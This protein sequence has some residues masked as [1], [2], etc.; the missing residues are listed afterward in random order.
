MKTEIVAL[1]GALLIGWGC[2]RPIP[3]EGGPKDTTPPKI[4][5]AKSTPNGALYFQDRAIYLTFDEW[6]TLQNVN[7]ELLVSP[8]LA[9]RPEVY[10]K[11]RTVILRFHEDEVLRPNTTYVIY[12]GTAVRDLHE[13]NP[14]Q[15]LR[16][17]FSTGDHLDS[18]SVLGVVVDAFSNE[19]VENAAV[20]LYD[21]FT[22]SA[23]VAER[24]YYLIRTDKSGQF[25]LPNVRPGIYR[26]IAVEDAD[27]NLRWK[28]EAERIAFLD[29]FVVVGPT[30]TLVSVPV[31]RM[32]APAPKG[33]LVMRRANQYGVVYLGF[34]I[35]PDSPNVRT[36]P[37]SIR[38]TTSREQDTLIVWYDNPDSLAWKLMVQGDTVPVR[39]LSKATF[40]KQH[41]LF[42]GDERIGP[43]AAGRRPVQ[44]TTPAALPPPRTITVRSGR[45][46]LIPF[47]SPIETVDT[48]RV[49][50]LADSLERRDFSLTKDS[51]Q[52]LTLRLSLSWERG[53]RY[54]L[55][56]LPG[57]LTDFWG[58]VNTDTLV[59]IFSVPTEK[60]VGTLMLSLENLTPNTSY[61]VRLLNGNNLEEERFFIA[62]G[63]AQREI[64]VDLAPVSYSVQLIED[65]N[66][67]RRWDGGDYFTNRQPER[68]FSKK[69]D[70]LRPN[71]DMEFSFP[72]PSDAP[73]GR[74]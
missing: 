12:L 24:P 5:A 57:A 36:E 16:F 7:T 34:G 52:P 66:A 71:W 19:P 46:A 42:F 33:R 64:F 22:D 69:L 70:A 63:T 27:Q 21:N 53:R 55:T 26:C 47:N 43:P 56:M 45:P 17:V 25:R 60:Q 73:R 72:L 10:L 23:I 20:M 4:V 65:T 37:P 28:P 40:L 62:Q 9:Q 68:V 49:A 2:A 74:E 1:A 35:L 31:L 58:A 3:P 67:N 59:R 39:A 15:D 8:P 32:S 13:D 29:S 30:D 6:V 50:L 41:R 14:A 44:P 48:S 51:A 18:A 54:T 11:K 61:I 38:W